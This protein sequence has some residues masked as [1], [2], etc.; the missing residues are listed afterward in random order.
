ML[1]LTI[2]ALL[3]ALST[4][5]AEQAN[6]QPGSPG[7]RSDTRVLVWEVVREGLEL[8]RVRIDLS[9]AYRE[10]MEAYRRQVETYRREVAA[11]AEVSDVLPQ[12]DELPAVSEELPMVSVLMERNAETSER[13]GLFRVRWDQREVANVDLLEINPN[14]YVVVGVSGS[15]SLK[16]PLGTWHV[17]EEGVPDFYPGDLYPGRALI[18]GDIRGDL[19]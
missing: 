16:A 10:Q 15:V 2:F 12:T 14:L 4:V 3:L 19:Q 6:A 13:F 1:R 7:A 9:E 17:E 18:R 8:N 11:F 5:V